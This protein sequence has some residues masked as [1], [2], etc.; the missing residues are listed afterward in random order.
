[1][2]DSSVVRRDKNEFGKWLHKWFGTNRGTHWTLP[3]L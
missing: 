2:T 1:M 3:V